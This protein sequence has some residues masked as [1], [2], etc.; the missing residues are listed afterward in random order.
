MNTWWREEVLKE[1]RKE[2]QERSL[3]EFLNEIEE[4]MFETLGGQ[5]PVI[6][7]WQYIAGP[8]LYGNVYLESVEENSMTVKC[9]HPAF[10]SYF[11]MHQTEILARL[12]EKFP[13]FNIR[14]VRITV[15]S[16]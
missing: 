7:Y 11:R 16:L 4:Y 12:R 6:K 2:W 13:S 8:V 3:G 14:K 10:A 5:E 1:K 9:T 15:G